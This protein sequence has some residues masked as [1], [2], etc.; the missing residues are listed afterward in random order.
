MGA[1]EHVHYREHYEEQVFSGGSR[2]GKARG[3]GAAAPCFPAG[4]A[5]KACTVHHA[6]TEHAR[7]FEE[8]MTKSNV[9]N[10]FMK[11]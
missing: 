11:F 4:A 9:A 8:V 1:K 5:H 10:E 3:R 6:T 2:G 7:S